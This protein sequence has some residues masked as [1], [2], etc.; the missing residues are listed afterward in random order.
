MKENMLIIKIRDNYKYFGGLSLVYGL[1]FTFCLYKNLSG[2]TFPVCIGVT[3]VFAILFMK[4][5]N[6]KIM[7]H[8][9]PYMAGM[10][11]LGISS[12]FTTSV[13]LHIFNIVGILLLFMVF[14]IHQFYNDYVWNFPAYLKRIFILVGTTIQ[15]VPYIYWHGG[16]FFSKNKDNRKNNTLIA[17]VIGFIAAMAVLCITLP[18]LLRSDIIFSKLFGKIL[19]HINFA[20]LFWI[21]LTFI[22]G[23]TLPYS[24][25]IAL[26]RYNLNQYNEGVD[27][28]AK[29]NG[30]G[31]YPGG[32]LSPR[33]F[34]PIIGITFTSIISLIYLI[35]CAIQIMYLFIGMRIGLP[36]QVTYAEYARSGFWELLFVSVI[37]FIMILLCMYLFRENVVLKVILTVICGCTFVMILSSGYRM[38]MYVGEYYLTFLRVLV[39]WFLIVLAL[40]IAGMVV[41]IYKKRFPLFH[42]IVAVVGVMYIGFSFSRPDVIVAKYDIARWKGTSDADFYYLMYEVSSIDAAPELAK[43]DFNDEEWASVDNGFIQQSMY[44][45]FLYISENNEGIFFR[46]ANYSRI[47][48]KLAAERYIEEHKDDINSNYSR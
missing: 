17:V 21:N 46:K 24:F 4:K 40:I 34:D 44:N 33:N 11:L 42:Y 16:W 22:L 1:I 39:L 31:E 15:S 29:G 3:I 9:L 35:Y 28:T 7:K 41:S 47:R 12:A 45:Y 10:I 36:E 19:E 5:I 6:Y 20:S 37:N 13:F 2:I 18:L 30:P 23:F 8:S 25:F 38:M 14:M 27:I 48:A 26:C 43:I 32:R